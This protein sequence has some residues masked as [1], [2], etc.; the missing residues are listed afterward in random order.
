MIRI[1]EPE[2]MVDPA[3]C[4]QFASA[5]SQQRENLF[6]KK[7]KQ[8]FTLAGQVADLGCGPGTYDILLCDTF[9]HIHIDAYDA[10]QPM[11]DLAQQQR[12]SRISWIHSEFE[13]IDRVYDSVISVDTLHHVHD[14]LTFWHTV[15]RIS[16]PGSQVFVMDHVRPINQTVLDRIVNSMSTTNDAIY[17]TDFRNSLL[18][19]HS[20]QEIQQQL[21]QAG[22][23]WLTVSTVGTLFQICFI[24]GIKPDSD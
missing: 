7:L 8:T 24:I 6:L 19:A 15:N 22:L 5:R 21:N 12:S 23:N 3:Q 10:S 16:Q 17:M 9:E 14:P 1:T 2:L 20:V 18:A 4:K 11:L 13:N